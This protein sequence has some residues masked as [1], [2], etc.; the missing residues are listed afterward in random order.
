[1][2]LTCINYVENLN[3]IACEC[4]QQIM[5]FQ[6]SKRITEIPIPQLT[7]FSSQIDTNNRT[8]NKPSED[9]KQQI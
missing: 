3:I 9:E 7:C 5:D 1:M 6:L 4:R 8:Q 2:L